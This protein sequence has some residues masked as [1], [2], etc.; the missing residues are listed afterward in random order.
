MEALFETSFGHFKIKLYAAKAPVTVKN[1]VDLATGNKLFTDPETGQPSKKP[2][3][4][5]L[6]FHAVIKDV[7]VQTGCPYS[8]G[9]GGPGYLFK[10]EINPETNKHNRAGLVSMANFAPDSNGSQFFITLNPLP[11]LDKT[12][13]IFGE[14]TEGLD[15]IIN[16]ANTTETYGNLPL[17]PPKLLKVTV[18]NSE[19]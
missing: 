3:Y 7:L 13:T 9:E 16:M 14:V 2:F 1:F 17:N 19:T 4:D 12:N 10:D 8:N 15:L 11:W 5:G 18:L 6:V